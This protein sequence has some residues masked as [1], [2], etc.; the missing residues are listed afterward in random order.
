[1]CKPSPNQIVR[2]SPN[3]HIGDFDCGAGDLND[4]LRDD[5]LH[6]LQQLLAV[7]YLLMDQDQII[8]FFSVS[9]DMLKYDP[10]SAAIKRIWRQLTHKIPHEK[11]RR[12][13][14]AVKLGRFGVTHTMQSKGLGTE[15]LDWIKMSFVTKNKTGCRFIT[16]DA[17]NNPRTLKFYQDN[18]FAFF[19]SDD[20]KEDTRQMWYDLKPFHDKIFQEN[21]TQP[22]VTSGSNSA[23][24]PA[25]GSPT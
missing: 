11:W 4:F 21:I 6:Y 24:T 22:A 23:A 14:P 12:S 1:M 3:T 25:A 18:E 7:T 10:N 19:T 20:E 5:A 2:L 9:N 17:N 16:V 8:A 15:I 13:Y